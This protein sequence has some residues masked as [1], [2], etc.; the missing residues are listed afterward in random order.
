MEEAVLAWRKAFD[1]AAQR[2]I[3]QFLPGLHAGV[4]NAMSSPAA[5]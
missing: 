1:I 3:D 2:A 4:Q 5:S